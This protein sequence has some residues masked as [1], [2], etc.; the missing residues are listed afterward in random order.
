MSLD[1]IIQQLTQFDLH[2]TAAETVTGNGT[3]VDMTTLEGIAAVILDSAGGAGTTPT[4][5]VKLQ[6]SATLGGSYVDIAGAVFA[7]VDD[8]PASRQ[9]IKFNASEADN[10]VRAVWTIT[11]SAGQS[12]TFSANLLGVKKYNN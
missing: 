6:H 9:M 12:F 11:G 4:L 3:G 1:R 7:E 5:N 2:P 8:T 10:F